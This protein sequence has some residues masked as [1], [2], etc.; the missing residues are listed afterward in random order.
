MMFQLLLSVFLPFSLGLILII[1][2][3]PSKTI[4]E[5][6]VV[7]GISFGLGLGI[8][9]IFLFIWLLVFGAEYR[10]FLLFENTL[11]IFLIALFFY[12]IKKGKIV[13]NNDTHPKGPVDLTFFKNLSKIFYILIVFSLASFAL[14]SVREPHGAWDA[15]AIWNL[16]A[17]FIFSGEES[18]RSLF[19]NLLDWSH[20]DYPLLLP[21]G[22]VNGWIRV[23]FESTTVPALFAFL[24]TFSIV[25]LLWSSIKIL[26]TESQGVLAGLAIL[27]TSAFITLG[28][29]QYADV[30]ISF[31]LLSTLVLLVF[32]D[33]S[34]N[35]KLLVLAG[36]MAG[37]SVW[38]KNE[39]WVLIL[40][41]IAAR[42][43]TFASP[44]RWI[45]IICEM[46]YFAVGLAPVLMVVIYFKLNLAPQNDLLSAQGA[47]TILKLTDFSRYVQV[48]KSYFLTSIKFTNSL[49]SLPLLIFYRYLIGTD[50]NNKASSIFILYSLLFILMGYFFVYISTPKDLVWHL[51]SSLNRLFL[52]LWPSFIFYFFL[53]VKTPE[54]IADIL[55]RKKE[56]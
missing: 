43:F 33:K 12:A 30:P 22:I 45:D 40:S 55:D 23:G 44:R 34:G 8:L 54:Q 42:V 31:F 27:G 15:L 38:T 14:R 13:F 18:W 35:H 50:K 46:L 17:R 36:F 3:W 2:L 25:L 20:P 11:L 53:I 29:A 28:A 5:L 24:F 26:R 10:E 16:H 6:L 32:F 9:S 21:L 48:I 41:L 7:M 4:N 1:Y 52:Q 39:G 56:K 47:E 19:S 37:L 51:N 49:V